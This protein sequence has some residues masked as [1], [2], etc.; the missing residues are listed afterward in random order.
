MVIININVVFPVVIVGLMA[1]IIYF[2]KNPE[3]I[4]KWSYLFYKYLHWK[5]ENRE[6]KIIS[7]NLDYR[8]TTVAK[9][10]NKEATGILPFGI[11][12][13]WRKTGEIESF[14]QK[15]E[16]IVVLRK[17]ENFDKNIIEACAA[18]VPKALLPKS[19]NV[20]DQNLLE[21]IDHYMIKKI[22]IEGSYDS[23][24]NYFMRNVLSSKLNKNNYFKKY[25]D[26][27][28]NLD[29]IG[30]FTRILLEEF[31]RLGIQLYGTIEEVKFKKET[32]DFLLFL[33]NFYL[34]TPGDDTTKLE[35]LGKKI[36]ICVVWVARQRTLKDWG[37]NAHI[38]RIKKDYELGAQ[39]IFIFS[40]SLP[41]YQS[42]TDSNGYVKEVQKKKTFLALNQVEN[43]CRQL[44]FL[45]LIKKQKYFTYDVTGMK[46]SAK[47]LLY[48][49][50]R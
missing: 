36:K 47:Y 14:V 21:T 8:I 32:I 16:V 29:T 34:R 50:M 46:R 41:A 18:Y 27:I 26:D 7:T 39:R 9:N 13:K 25:Y 33:R 30:Y 20:I 5:S 24:Y 1:L 40:Y 48:E 23:A 6:R 4:D 38:N 17:E 2:L 35:F 49:T 43:A 15:N 28:T 44:E 12:I 42:I 10:I 37:I 3:K 22:L 45:R 19:R 31:R 11:R